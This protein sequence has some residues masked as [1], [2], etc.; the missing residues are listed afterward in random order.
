VIQWVVCQQGL[1][2]P[3]V[4]V[5]LLNL[6]AEE[7]SRASR[8]SLVIKNVARL[9]C[10]DRLWHVNQGQWRGEWP[11]VADLVTD[12]AHGTAHNVSRGSSDLEE[13]YYSGSSPLEEFHYP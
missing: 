12:V 13:C 6:S 8:M 7:Y 1:T 5:Q 2:C 10:K 3:R 11:L 9:H 4:K